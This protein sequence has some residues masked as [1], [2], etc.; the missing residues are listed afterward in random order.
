MVSL[1]FT[2]IQYIKNTFVFQKYTD[3]V[4][5]KYIYIIH[6]YTKAHTHRYK[7]KIQLKKTNKNLNDNVV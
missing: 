6:I 4:L 7:K 5:N 2:N 1:S 3:T